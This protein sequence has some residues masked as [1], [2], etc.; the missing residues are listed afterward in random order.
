MLSYASWPVQRAEAVAPSEWAQVLARQLASVRSQL[1]RE[2]TVQPRGVGW[3]EGL[4]VN[5]SE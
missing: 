5:T 1:C 3:L 4:R 2:E